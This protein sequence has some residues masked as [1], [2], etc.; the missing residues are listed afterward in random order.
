LRRRTSK[1]VLLLLGLAAAIWAFLAVAAVRH[2]YFDLRVYYGALNHWASGGGELYDYLLPQSRYGFTYPPFAAL[3]MF[4]MA[5]VGW[6]V[7]ILISI[8][9][10]V[11]ATF[12]LFYWL[13]DPISRRQGWTRWFAIGIAIC[14]GAAFEPLRETVNFG[15]VNMLLVVLV[16]ADVLLL[17]NA[18]RRF[19]GVGLGRLAGIG[20]GLAT[21]IKLTPGIFIVYLLITR[22]WRAAAVASGT[23]LAATGLAGAVAPGASR[24]F[25]T[26]ALWNTDR[27][28]TPAFVSNQ[29]LNGM[30]TRL[31]PGHPPKLVWVALVLA[32][33]A[34]W[35]WRARRAVAGGDEAAG[36]ALTGL[37][38]V[39][40]SPFTWVHH[41]V[42]VLPAIILLVDNGL[43]AE[44]RRRRYWLLGLAIFTYGVMCS[45]LVWAFNGRFE[46]W[47][48][49]FGS[50]AYVWLTLV[51]LVA[52]PLR[53]AAPPHI[54]VPRSS[55]PI[56]DVPDLGELDGRVVAAFD[57]KRARESVDDKSGALVEQSRTLVSAEHP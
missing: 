17:M 48:G 25:W 52:L 13:V 4:P 15:Q 18:E 10:T 16:G 41:L 49:W 36:F 30:V 21:A 3:V 19:A 29:S 35:A 33:V 7:A 11:F 34:I 26:D 37:V 53:T 6:H 45:R 57:S 28:G 23:T 38:A 44:S 55:R 51:L 42:W 46:S 27:V 24:E 20:I 8:A 9:L 50:N 32:V 47:A 43:A 39:L 12:A 54:T 56:E 2:G 22:R 40:I 1:Q 31:D 5:Y 14:L